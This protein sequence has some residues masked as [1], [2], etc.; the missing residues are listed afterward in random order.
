MPAPTVGCRA[1]GRRRPRSIRPRT[2][3]LLLGLIALPLPA[4]EDGTAEPVVP[5]VWF[6]RSKDV[7]RLGSNVAWIETDAG[8]VVVDTA[9]PRGAE[10]ALRAIAA[11]TSKPIRY[12][13]MTHHHPDHSFGSGAFAA[14]GATVVAHENA[15]AAYRRAAAEN[16]RT[17][18]ET[19][20]ASRKYEPH[21]PDL[22]FSDRLT[23]G[24]GEHAIELLHF[25]HAHTAGDLVVWLP[26][27][28]VLLTGDACVNGP[29]SYLGDAD[30][31]SWIEVLGRLQTLGAKVVVPGHGAVG[32]PELLTQRRAYLRE[33]RAEVGRLLNEGRRGE[34]IAGAAVVPTW[35]RW[36]DGPLDPSH[37]AHVEAE[38]L[39]GPGSALASRTGEAVA[40]PMP[41]DPAQ[42]KFL[43]GPLSTE[44][45]AT[46]RTLAPNVEILTAD[47]DESALALAGDVHGCEARFVSA[48]FLAR[49]KELRWVQAMSAGVESLVAQPALVDGP[50]VLTNMAGMYGTAIADHV[51]AM[52]L[53][54]VRGL[55][56]WI[57]HQRAGAWADGDAVPQDELHGKTMLVLGLGGIGREVA[58]RA[59]ACGMR[60]LATDPHATTIPAFVERVAEP[61]ALDAILP[62]ADVVVVCLPLTPQTRGLFGRERLHGMK[63][64]ALLVNVARGAIV[65]TAALTAALEAG[66]LG[67]AALDVVDPEPLPAD[68]PLWTNPRVLLTPHVAGRSPISATRRFEMF[69]ENMRRFARGLPLLNVVDKRAGY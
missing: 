38:L 44:E 18:Q 45:L 11:T 20:E 47:S 28:R 27:K 63:R 9:F 14:V 32:G 33:L 46:L 61:A 60:V 42:L 39:R 56:Q 51:L 24:E 21:A 1:A 2:L 49:A 67:G 53:A 43:A 31:A 7:S 10:R 55:P 57:E 52:T 68:N 5:G 65:D 48:D 6:L 64:G 29:M 59:H 35:R 4:Q 40:I 22:T 23:L 25:G 58:K 17:R 37:A 41:G 19:D 3:L 69:A 26:K 16:Y 8:V 50:A 15:A 34:A 12:V 54:L 30:T 13:V 62:D 36:T 66:E